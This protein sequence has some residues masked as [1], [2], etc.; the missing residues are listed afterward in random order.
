LLTIPRGG[1]FETLCYRNPPRVQVR[2]NEKIN[3]KWEHILPLVTIE[4]RGFQLLILIRLVSPLGLEG[5]K[6][7]PESRPGRRSV[8]GASLQSL[9]GTRSPLGHR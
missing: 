4:K 3:K 1:G 5:F 9:Y 6:L 2:Y 7:S 8:C